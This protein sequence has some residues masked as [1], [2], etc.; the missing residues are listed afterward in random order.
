MMNKFSIALI[1]CAS[2]LVACGG[3]DNGIE[4]APQ[5]ATPS[6]ETSPADTTADGTMSDGT[7]A[8]G[9]L[10]EGMGE[11]MAADDS[12]FGDTGS[13]VYVYEGVDLSAPYTYTDPSWATADFHVAGSEFV[14]L[15]EN[16]GNV[17]A[18]GDAVVIQGEF[19][20]DTS[21]STR[22]G[23][24]YRV[25]T[26]A[27]ALFSDSMVEVTVRARGGDFS[28]LYFTNQVGN[29]GIQRFEGSSDWQTY[30]F[31]YDIPAMIDAQ[32]D[33]IS[34]LPSSDDPVQVSGIAVNVME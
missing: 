25:D 15:P 9:G 13:S 32:G 17:M 2:V 27:E 4:E 5:T 12:A 11:S 8:D 7:M 10:D 16:E 20:A 33:M 23:A 3:S 26:E 18:A 21:H 19:A 28:V 6:E 29:S 1:G 14:S 31:T 30:S 24:V 22:S 34:V